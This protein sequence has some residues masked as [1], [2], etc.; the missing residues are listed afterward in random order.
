M[1]NKNVCPTVPPLYTWDSGTSDI[2]RDDSWDKRGTKSLKALA[3][4]VL[5][6]PLDRDKVGQDV[7]QALK[8]CPKQ[9]APVGQNSEELPK[10][11]EVAF[12]LEEEQHA[13]ALAH[14]RR[15][16]VDCP[17][18]GGK[19]H[20]WHCSRCPGAATCQ[21]W[22]ERRLDVEF[23]RQSEKPYSLHLVEALEGP[24]VLQ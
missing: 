23:F 6:V 12:H 9:E 15:L 21:A 5:A 2:E 13:A 8:S 7:G 20:C 14:A 4:A 17:V 1:N 19:R 18:V 22:H 24:G 3:L 16:L 11:H 10:V